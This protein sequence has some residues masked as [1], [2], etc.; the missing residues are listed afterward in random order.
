MKNTL[1][2]INRLENTEEWIS[3][4]KGKIMRI[5]QSEQEKQ[6]FKKQG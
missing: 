2:E 1:E 5:T 4:L 3:D 6:Y